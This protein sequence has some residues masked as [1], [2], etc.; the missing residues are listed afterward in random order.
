MLLCFSLLRYDCRHFRS[1]VP[2][3]QEKLRELL[4]AA[5]IGKQA[6]VVGAGIAGLTA[7]RSLADFF[8]HVVVLE[9][10]ALPTEATHRPGIP[11][12]RHI[13][14]LLAGGLQALSCLFPGF[15]ESLSQ[16]GAVRLR[17]GYDDRIEQPGYDPFPQRDLGIPVYGMTR[18][19]LELTVR[20]RV[21]KYSN[22]EVRQNCRAQKFITE[23]DD[24]AVTAVRCENSDGKSEQFQADLILDASGH[25]SLTEA[26][27]KSIGWP[28]PEETW[29]GIDL[30]YATA[31]FDLPED[32]PPDWMGVRT[33]AHYPDSKRAAI[34]PVEGKRWM[35]TLAGRYDE[36]PPGDRDGY[37]AFAQQ[38]RTPTIY[39]AIRHAK[40]VSEIARFG[41][42]GSCWRHF[43]RLEKLP[44]GLL[45][46]GDAICRFNPIYGQGM[47]VAALEADVLLR[48]LTAQSAESDGLAGLNVAFLA[49]TERLIDTPWWTA[50]IP[51]FSDP[52]TEGQRPLQ[53]EETFKFFAA[54]LKFAAQDA[55]IHKLFIEVQ[56]LL[57]PR[58]AYCDPDFCRRVKWLN[59]R[60]VGFFEAE[61]IMG[62]VATQGKRQ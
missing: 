43:E 28:I 11:Q 31:V 61:A 18:P 60:D 21:G 29:I 22:V 27:L 46:F 42:K 25:G 49:E 1:Y 37:L 10:D 35:V 5:L 4:M 14:V 3:P 55:S 50:A 8:E 34:V 51:D 54:L 17:M 7:A 39:N 47:S 62:S 38:L 48:L 40:P 30:G 58:T 45:P 26:L 33:L 16:T 57:K 53:L 20:K 9:S 19:L 41:F 15:V 6:V 13:H 59:G 12:S 52:R 56:N 2:P 32:F 24:A 44:R 36:K 23:S